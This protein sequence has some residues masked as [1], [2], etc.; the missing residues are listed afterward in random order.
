MMQNQIE[1]VMKRIFLVLSFFVLWFGELHADELDLSFQ[2]WKQTMESSARAL[3]ERCEISFD[4]SKGVLSVT[5]I[6]PL[7][8]MRDAITMQKVKVNALEPEAEAQSLKNVPESW[9]KWRC[10]NNQRAVETLRKTVIE[11][12][13]V[14]EFTKTSNTA[15]LV[16]TCQNGDRVQA[17]EQGARF[18]KEAQRVL[19]KP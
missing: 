8:P 11:Q 4:R 18:L 6:I 14:E 2:A 10:R 19:S 1:D 17:R 15:I 7:N 16:L 3:G 5:K 9:L 13:E 12:V